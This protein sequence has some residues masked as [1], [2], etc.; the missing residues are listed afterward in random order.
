[1]AKHRNR[2]DGLWFKAC[3]L[4]NTRCPERQSAV[5]EGC[6]YLTII[7]IEE[8]KAMEWNLTQKVSLSKFPHKYTPFVDR[9]TY[10]WF[11][12]IHTTPSWLDP[13]WSDHFRK[14]DVREYWNVCN[15]MCHIEKYQRNWLQHIYIYRL[16]TN[17][18]AKPVLEHKTLWRRAPGCLKK[19]WRDQLHQKDLKTG[20]KPSSVE[21]MINFLHKIKNMRLSSSG[22]QTMH[23][24]YWKENSGKRCFGKTEYI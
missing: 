18:I 5:L 22:R 3:H 7:Y 1:M 16:K 6:F 11:Q 20:I 8:A 2:N 17:R 24:N 13:A 15:I 4:Q 19:T 14:A 21:T 23:T 12:D 9:Q 10:I